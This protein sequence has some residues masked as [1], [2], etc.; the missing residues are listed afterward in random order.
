MSIANTNTGSFV[1]EDYGSPAA[2]VAR[3]V[4]VGIGGEPARLAREFVACRPVLLADVATRQALPRRVFCVNKLYRHPDKPAFVGNLGLQV[5][6][7]PRMQDAPLDFPSPNPRANTLEVFKRNPSFRAFSNSANLFGNHMV[8]KLHHSG[9]T[10]AE[11]MNDSAGRARAFLLQTFPLP[12]APGANTSHFAGI[13]KSL[14][15]GTL[16][17]V[18]KAKVYSKPF[19]ARGSFSFREIDRDEQVEDSRTAN[20]VCLT[21]LK[22]QHLALLC[23]GDKADVFHSSINRPNTH[24]VV[25]EI[26]RQKAFVIRKRA[27]RFKSTL[28]VAI[29]LVGIHDLAD[30]SHHR[31]SR[32]AWKFFTATVVSQFVQRKLSEC[33]RLQCLLRNPITGGI[34]GAKRF[35][36]RPRLSFVSQQFDHHSQLHDQTI[37]NT[38]SKASQFLSPQSAGF[39]GSNRK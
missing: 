16:S 23:T 35:P 29:K 37:V 22:V 9:L 24:R 7:G 13:P 12:P 31:L 3:C 34:N 21:A 32:K 19:L 4:G 2:D 14:P 30:G 10:P 28:N 5:R 1:R 8:L 26:P 18:H 6:E 39:H 17:E 36:E 25:G 27:E 11:T 33:F 20:K 38:L 15:V